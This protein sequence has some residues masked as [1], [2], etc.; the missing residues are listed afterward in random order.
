[1]CLAVPGRVIEVIGEEIFKK[2]K[3]DF[4]GLVREVCFSYLPDVDV[5]D[6]VIVHV[7]FA[8]AKLNQQEAEKQLKLLEE[9]LQYE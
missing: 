5:G 8:I 9:F 7:G 4:S 2:G 6:W 1:M 3:V